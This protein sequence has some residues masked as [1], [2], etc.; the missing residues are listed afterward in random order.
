MKIYKRFN[1]AFLA[2]TLPS[3][4]SLGLFN[5]AIDP[6]G[7]FNSPEILRLNSLKPKQFLNVRLFKAIKI[8]QIK[9]KTL[10]LGSSRTDLGLNPQHP[11]LASKQPA[12]NL[13]LVG[14]NIYE[15]KRY[16]EHTLKNQPELETVVLGIDLFMFNEHKQNAIDFAESRLEKENVTWSDLLNMT[17][18][19]NAIEASVETIKS[20]NNSDAYYLYH[21]HGLRYV[22]QNKPHQSPRKRFKGSLYG[23]FNSNEYYHNYKLSA[24]FL[25][26]FKDI[27][28]ICEQRN[29]ELKVFISPSHASQWESLYISGLWEVFEQWKREL[30]KIT[31]IWDF[32]GYN[33]ITTE[34]IGKEMKNYWDSSHYRQ[35]VGDLV[36]DRLFNTPENKVPSDFGILVTNNKIESHLANIRTERE[37]WVKNHPEIVDF[38]NASIQ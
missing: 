25:Q 23:L 24:K 2:F 17:L 8:T 3:L 7:V 16:F 33:T 36:L 12:Y 28:A 38:I 35:E 15:I 13:G 18:S 11:S 22:Y 37:L 27:V 21:P 31:P 29:I 34:L 32:S 26:D 10:L 14:P 6:Y 20:S 30:V 5:I 9:P 19:T 4:L 1:I